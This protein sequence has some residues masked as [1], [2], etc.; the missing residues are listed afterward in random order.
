MK[1]I[2]ISIV[3]IS[4]IL[5]AEGVFSGNNNQSNLNEES[6]FTERLYL[7]AGLSW[8]SISSDDVECRLSGLGVVGYD[9]NENLD[10]EGRYYYGIGGHYSSY[11]IYVKPKIDDFYFLV[12]YGGTEYEETGETFEGGRLGMG[13][14]FYPKL[15]ADAV[16]KCEEESDISRIG[17]YTVFCQSSFRDEMVQEKVAGSTELP[18]KRR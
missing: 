15:S 18:G 7:K 10:F 14:V 5:S 6:T 8:T 12:G 3:A 9:Y 11:G 1:K 17:L 13:L 2:I 16:Y 4:S